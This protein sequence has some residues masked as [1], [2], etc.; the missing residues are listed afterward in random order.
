MTKR[1][2]RYISKDRKIN[3]HFW[4]FCEGETEEAYVCYLR[5]KYRIHI[6]IVSKITGSG[7]NQKFI[8]NYKKG[9]P[10]HE[11]DKDF[12]LYDADEPNVLSRMKELKAKLILSNP[13][14]ELWFLLHYKNQTSSLSTKECLRDLKNRNKSYIKGFIDSKLKEKLDSKTTDARNRAKKL[15]LHENPSSNIF[16]FIEIIEENK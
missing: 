1:N 2:K 3:P 9:K 10:T 15:L 14:I 12:L 16:E 5:T 4:V 6:E 11:K 8:T 7:I 13:C